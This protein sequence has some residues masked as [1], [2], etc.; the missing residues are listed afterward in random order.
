MTHLN[1]ADKQS[2]LNFRFS[3][4]VRKLC[5]LNP[6][7]LPDGVLRA[8]DWRAHIAGSPVVASANLASD[9][10]P[11]FACKSTQA[12]AATSRVLD[13]LTLELVDHVMV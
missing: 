11:E 4:C 9:L 12:K 10:V 2:D 13:V 6:L 3:V 1:V 8:L 5:E 7:R